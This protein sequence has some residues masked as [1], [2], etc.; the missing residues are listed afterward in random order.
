[1]PIVGRDPLA[2]ES[3]IVSN[4]KLP[5]NCRDRTATATQPHGNLGKREVGRAQKSSDFLQFLGRE[6]LALLPDHL[7]HSLSKINGT[8]VEMGSFFS[9]VLLCLRNVR[10]VYTIG[11]LWTKGLR[12]PGWPGT[13]VGTY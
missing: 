2:S 4:L 13:I 11:W 6:I 1:M 12:R 3:S 7:K 10:H 8:K 9:A 5:I